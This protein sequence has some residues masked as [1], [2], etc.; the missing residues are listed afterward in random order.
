[1]D[2]I[3][4][5]ENCNEVPTDR[6]F[7]NLISL[8]SNRYRRGEGRVVERTLIFRMVRLVLLLMTA[9]MWTS[10]PKKKAPLSRL[11][12]MSMW[13]ADSANRWLACPDGRPSGISG[14]FNTLASSIGSLDFI[15]HTRARA[16]THT[17]IHPTAQ[18]TK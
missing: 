15:P 4:K 16:H 2:D 8:Q 6:L 17:H 5:K 14:K 13:P 3:D 1:M 9:L 11:S 18:K 7:G 10:S 12:S